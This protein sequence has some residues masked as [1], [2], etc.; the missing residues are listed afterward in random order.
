MLRL[1]VQCCDS[2]HNVATLRRNATAT[3]LQ[4]LQHKEKLGGTKSKGHSAKAAARRA[5]ATAKRANAAAQRATAMEQRANA[6]AQREKCRGTKNKCCSTKTNVKRQCQWQ[7]QAT[8]AAQVD[9]K[10]KNNATCKLD[11]FSFLIVN[12][13][14][15]FQ[16]VSGVLGPGRLFQC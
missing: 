2:M 3:T 10:K 9:C 4:T 15:L 1:D 5:N 11:F 14:S 12:G 6:A 7:Q 16:K 8:T 13:F